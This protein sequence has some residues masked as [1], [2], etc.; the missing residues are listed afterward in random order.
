MY[1][2]GTDY[3][4]SSLLWLLAIS[5][6]VYTVKKQIMKLFYPK[7]TLDLFIS[8][9]KIFL[10][11]KYP[12]IAFDYTIIKL[13]AT[14]KNPELRKYMI[15]DDII[16]Q[17]KRITIN[18]SKYPKSTPKKLQWSSYIF[19]SEPIKNKLPKDWIQR[20]NALCLRDNRKCFRC[21]TS[22]D[23]NNVYPKMI[24]PLENGGKYYLENLI[25]LCSDCDKILNNDPK[26]NSF[27]NIKDN[28]YDIVENS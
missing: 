17:F 8:K 13:S 12:D 24:K 21:S 4:I 27:L 28:L 16:D 22:V 5:I 11:K 7:T 6:F 26:K 19:N 3:I 1:F 14:E 9:L 20:K 25:P 18:T 10:V 2:L 23:M 15:V